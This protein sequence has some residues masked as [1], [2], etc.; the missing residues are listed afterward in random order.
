M[1]RLNNVVKRFGAHE[2]LAGAHFSIARGERV[3]IV[4]PNGAGKTTLL[5]ILCSLEPYDEGE[6]CVG[7]RDVSSAAPSELPV[8]VALPLLPHMRVRRNLEYKLVML[9][10]SRGEVEQR[11][12]ETIRLL[13][14]DPE[15]MN[16]FPH[17]LSD[18]QRQRAV[19]AMM[20][21]C[22]KEKPVLLF[23]EPLR[24]LDTIGKEKAEREFKELFDAIDATVLYVTHDRR[25]AVSIVGEHGRFIVMSENPGSVAQSG[26]LDE[27]VQN[28]ANEFVRRFFTEWVEREIRFADRLKDVGTRRD[29][30]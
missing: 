20:L 29:G 26:T 5:R 3:V 24:H 22:R 17:Q 16:R 30:S 1:I 10:L 25:E 19:L 15:L 28:P 2:A 4:G 13:D 18:G 27:L 14:I 12:A 7:G 6:V 9:G 23:D 11:V 8:S 21:V